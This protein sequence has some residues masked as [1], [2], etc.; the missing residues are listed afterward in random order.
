MTI[1]RT[2]RVLVVEDSPTDQYL[3]R[4]ALERCQEIDFDIEVLTSTKGLSRLLDTIEVDLML[5]DY[6]LPGQSGLEFLRGLPVGQELP[7]IIM[8][9]GS[10]DELVAKEAILAG[11]YDYFLKARIEPEALGTA[12]SEC[13]KKATRE[14]AAR[15]QKLETER[16]AVIDALTD[17]Y[18]R[19]Y[20]A[21]AVRRECGRVGRYG[22]T[23][24][25]LMIDIDG[26]KQYNDLYGHLQGDAILRQVAS[27]ISGSIRD[28][29]I[30]ARFGGDEFCVVLTETN[31]EGALHLAERLRTSI[32]EQC[33]V[34]GGRALPVTASIGVLTTAGQP[35]PY[36]ESIIE[37]ADTALRRAKTA[38]KNQVHAT[39]TGVDRDIVRT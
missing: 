8:L 33:L 30:A 20:L 16:L 39:C 24:S 26:F 5:L 9:T 29:D 14:K 11:A 1:R 6:D 4:R 31:H 17:L 36:P 2:V 19:R 10:G 27:L 28:C 12:I 25:C 18:N 22:G 21:D 7:P 34:A 38:G 15:R 3:I 37:G 32:A 35:I 23:L 13:L